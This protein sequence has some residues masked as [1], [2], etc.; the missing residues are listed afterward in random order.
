MKG[1]NGKFFNDYLEKGLN[2]I[3]SLLNVLMVWWYDNVVYIGDV[4]KMFN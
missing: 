1:L 3:N 4:C 2:Y